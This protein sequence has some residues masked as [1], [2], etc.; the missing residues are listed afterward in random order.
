MIPPPPR[1]TLFPY[2]TLFR[3]LYAGLFDDRIRQVILKDPSESHQQGPALLNVLRITDIPEVAAAFAPRKL[4]VLGK[5]PAPFAYARGIYGLYER[6]ENLT[7][8]GS[9]PEAMEVWK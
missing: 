5:I 3:S 1:S 2:T 8:I 4:V 6:P 9:M 7:S